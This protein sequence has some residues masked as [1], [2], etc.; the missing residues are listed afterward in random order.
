MGLRLPASE[1]QAAMTVLS[2]LGAV[3]IDNKRPCVCKCHSRCL[4]AGLQ[5][6]VALLDRLCAV[7]INNEV[8]RQILHSGDKMMC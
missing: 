1:L 2:N 4:S 3:A 6:D 8:L 7:T 5:A